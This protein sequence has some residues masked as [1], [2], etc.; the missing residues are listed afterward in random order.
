LLFVSPTIALFVKAPAGEQFSVIYVLGQNHT[1]DNIP[2][3]IKAGQTYLVY[4]GVTNHMSFSNYYTCSVK[5]A[6]QGDHLPDP[7]LGTQ[8]SL[9]VLYEYKTFLD[10]EE[11]WEVPLT[12][13]VNNVTFANGV[14]TVSEITINGVDFQI[15]K[16]SSLDTSTLGYGYNLIVELSR[17]NSA[18]NN[19]IYDGRFVTLNLNIVQ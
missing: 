11:T 4:L 17:Y 14:S 1:F 18:I 5:F 13:E 15:S 2:F 7:I 9:P 8:S 16:T 12:F 3:N 19:I 6:S 10:K